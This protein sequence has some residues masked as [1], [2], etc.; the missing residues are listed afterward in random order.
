VS[1]EVHFS[2]KDWARVEGAWTAWWSGELERPLVMIEDLVPP[3]GLDVSNVLDLGPPAITFPLEQPAD[4]IIDYY[5]VRLEAKRFYGDAWPKWWPNFGP[6]ILAGF[7]GARVHASADTTWFEPT[8]VV[9]ITGLNPAHDP[10]NGWWQ[11][12]WELTRMA[13]ERWGSRVAVGHTDLGGNL[14]V[15]ASLLITERLLF[16][17]S[18]HPE[19]VARLAGS[20]TQLWLRY[21]DELHALVEP[22]GRGTTPWAAIWSPLRCYMLQSDFAYMI[23]PRMFER[24]VL[25]DIAACCEALDH[26]FYHLDGIGQI[27][28]LD[29]LLS[30]ERLRGIQ[31]IPGDG[32]PPPEAWL[33]LLQRIREAG[34]LCQLYVSPDGARKI[35][36]ELSGRGFA[37]YI[38]QPMSREEAER[39]LLAIQRDQD[40]R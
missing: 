2:E 18:D 24:Y 12:V 25:P 3:P 15:L 34:K 37:F 17:L 19:E 8:E 35:T 5:G 4:E 10:G 28:H 27:P 16:D 29:M 23:S 31:W 6:G 13:V 20:I 1:I 22:A 9:P 38:D 40:S 36:R 7:L 33:P 32:Q 11:R 39:F 14:D 30:L 26:A 21:Y